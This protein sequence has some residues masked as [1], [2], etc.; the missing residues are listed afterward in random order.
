MRV[1][2]TLYERWL[3]WTA[4]RKQEDLEG[5]AWL[6]VNQGNAREGLEIL[7]LAWKLRRRWKT[8]RRLVRAS[9]KAL[10]PT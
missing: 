2:H 4:F 6:L 1:K 3:A 8:F 9:M 5:L 10:Q 7:R